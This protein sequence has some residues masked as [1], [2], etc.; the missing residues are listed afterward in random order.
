MR[1]AATKTAQAPALKAGGAARK[2]TAAIAALALALALAPQSFS[3]TSF[4]DLPESHWA[5]KAVSDMAEKGIVNGYPDGSF[6]PSGIVT[7][8]EFIK[9]AYVA[10]GGKELAPQGGDWAAPYYDAALEDGLYAKNAI[11]KAALPAPMPRGK[12]ALVLSNILGDTPLGDTYDKVQEGLGDIDA[13]TPNEYDIVKAAAAGLITGYPDGTFRPE[14]TLTRAEAATVVFRLM[15]P[16]ERQLPDLRDPSEK[17]ASE[18]LFDVIE[19]A[20]ANPDDAPANIEKI[21]DAIRASTSTR[22]ISEIVTDDPGGLLK[23]RGIGY[24]KNELGEWLEYNKETESLLYEEGYEFVQGDILYYEMVEEPVP[25]RIVPLSESGA[26]AE[27]LDIG[28]SGDGF[29]VKDGRAIGGVVHSYNT[30]ARFSHVEQI[31]PYGG[32]IPDFDYLVLYANQHD[33]VLVIPNNLD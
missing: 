10:Q 16:S 20:K 18:R 28:V 24:I 27:M 14:G 32:K 3:A 11:A 6:A 12:M 17:T 29:L 2:A 30:I 1:N 31:D 19:A 5:Y 15:D 7:Y 26:L 4:S 22:P 25:M 13:S 23:G 9:M 33:T 21:I 8:A